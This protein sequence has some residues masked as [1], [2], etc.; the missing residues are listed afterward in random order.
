MVEN[1]KQLQDGNQKVFQQIY[2][3]YIDLVGFIVRKFGVSG[4][5]LEEIVQDVFVSFY[6]HRMEIKS[7]DGIKPWLCV[8]ARNKAI[9]FL[10]KEKVKDKASD[11][12][13][14]SWDSN[15][16][17]HH[18]TWEATYFMAQIDK[19]VNSEKD[20]EILKLFYVDDLSCKEIAQRLG[21]TANTV[22]SNLSRLRKKVKDLCSDRENL[23]SETESK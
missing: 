9:D 11:E 22:S 15:S 16:S 4:A 6:M 1:F 5:S 7:A 20:G 13:E 3:Q 14:R 12:I 23:N 10:R 8:A 17:D 18:K 19:L 21:T 2:D